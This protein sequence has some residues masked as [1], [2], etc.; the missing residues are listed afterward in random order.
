MKREVQFVDMFIYIHLD[1]LSSA[2]ATSISMLHYLPVITCR[3][4]VYGC[5]LSLNKQYSDD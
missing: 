5:E 2:H 3:K 4:C 1:S